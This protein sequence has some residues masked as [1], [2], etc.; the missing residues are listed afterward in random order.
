[1]PLNQA[2][3]W[4]LFK[5][6]HFDWPLCCFGFVQAGG[7]MSGVSFSINNEVIFEQY[8]SLWLGEEN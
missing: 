4:W 7:P 1:M 3:D 8:S 5:K 6:A 2:S